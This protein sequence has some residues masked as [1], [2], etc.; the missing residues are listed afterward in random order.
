MVLSDSCAF[1]LI[2]PKL[3]RCYLSPSNIY[4]VIF[5][6]QAT[7]EVSVCR[8]RDIVSFNLRFNLFVSIPECSPYGTYDYFIVRDEEWIRDINNLNWD[9]IGRSEFYPMLS[10]ILSND[11]ILTIGDTILLIN[12]FKVPLFKI[13][14]KDCP[15]EE[16]PI[17]I[18][19]KKEIDEEPEGDYPRKLRICGRGLLKYY[20]KEEPEVLK[21]ETEYR[22]NRQLIQ[23]EG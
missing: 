5:Q 15:D 22:V 7:K 2:A 11:G 6:H 21:K 1:N 18:T 19:V 16:E 14:T 23:Y 13:D 17:Y 20:G 12:D 9:S 4:I 3:D 10:P 8:C